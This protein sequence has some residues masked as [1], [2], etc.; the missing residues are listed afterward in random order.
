MEELGASAD[1]CIFVGDGGSK[2]LYAARELGMKAVQATWFHEL[3]FE[4]HIPCPLLDV[5]PQGLRQLYI[6]IFL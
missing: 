6:L 3:A 1:E 4:P 2:E 5:F